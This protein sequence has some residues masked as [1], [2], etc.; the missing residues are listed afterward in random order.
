[1]SY[2]LTGS[3]EKCGAYMYKNTSWFRL[4]APNYNCSC[5]TTSLI[6]T[7]KEAEE[8]ERQRKIEDIKETLKK[9]EEYQKY[10]GIVMAVKF[11]KEGKCIKR[12]VWKEN[13]LLI[14]DNFGDIYITN[15]EGGMRDLHEEDIIAEDYYIIKEEE[16]RIY[17]GIKKAIELT[18]EGKKI[19]RKIW[20]EDEWLSYDLKY[21]SVRY[22]H[23]YFN[24][25]RLRD[26]NIDDLLAEDYYIEEE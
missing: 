1:M 12:Q 24:N 20:K 10:F 22:G 16:E 9:R 11:A 18:K 17:F 6:L 14:V 26:L 8:I 23:R 5:I 7:N 21:L 4:G 15:K 2:M 13:D 25:G 19:V 3:C